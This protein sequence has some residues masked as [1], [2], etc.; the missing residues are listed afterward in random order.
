[1]VAAAGLVH[2]CAR[3]RERIGRAAVAARR[4]GNAVASMGVDVAIVVHAAC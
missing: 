3:G 2:A 4:L 1:M